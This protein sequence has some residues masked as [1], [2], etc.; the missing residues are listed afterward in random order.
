SDAKN[1]GL[2]NQSGSFVAGPPAGK[3]RFAEHG[4]IEVAPDGRYLRHV[5]GTPY[6]W[7]GDTAWNGPLLSS[8]A[9]WEQYV[10][11]RERQ[12][13]NAVQWVTTQWRASPNGDASKHVAYTGTSKISINPEFF[14]RLDQKVDAMN[15]AGLLSVPVLLWAYNARD[16]AKIDPG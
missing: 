16:N 15:Q 14:Q 10:K 3:T 2:H 8:P 11:E 12:K 4:P 1:A 13:F 7:L 9:E 5:D 6:F